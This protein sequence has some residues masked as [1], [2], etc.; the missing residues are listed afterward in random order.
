M[1]GPKGSSKNRTVGKEGKEKLDSIKG[2][3]IPNGE[4]VLFGCSVTPPGNMVELESLKAWL[5]K[6]MEDV[7]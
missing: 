7:L 5:G 3:K 4:F 2:K 1:G 6:V